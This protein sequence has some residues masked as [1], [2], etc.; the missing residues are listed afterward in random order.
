MRCPPLARRRG[1][2]NLT[3]AGP[4]LLSGERCTD[5]R[6]FTRRVLP[7]PRAL[8]RQHLTSPVRARVRA[9]RAVPLGLSKEPNA[10]IIVPC[11]SW[12]RNRWTRMMRRSFLKGRD[13]GAFE[14]CPDPPVSEDCYDVTEAGMAQIE[15]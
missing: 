4:T 13:S 12:L 9:G 10:Q 1:D 6:L 8:C 7:P 2:G 15:D 11:S 5:E 14:G 3:D